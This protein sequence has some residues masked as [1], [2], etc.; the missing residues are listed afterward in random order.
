[1]TQTTQSIE[2]YR[3]FV[4]GEWVDSSSGAFFEVLNPY[5]GQAWARVPRGNGEDVNKAV[6]SAKKALESDSWKEMTGAARRNLL[7][8]LGKQIEQNAERLGMT[9]T[10]SN[11]K[12]Y[13]EIVPQAKS[14]SEFF[15]YYAGWAD[16]L[17]GE[18]I[19]LTETRDVLCYTLREP[20][21]VVA[22]VTPWNAPLLLTIMKMAPALA[23]GDTLVIKPSRYTPVTAIALA[24]MVEAAGFPPGVVNVVTGIGSEIGDTLL[25]HPD[26]NKISFTGSTDVGREV[27]R[28][29]SENIAKVTLELG[30]KSPNIVFEDAEMDNA[31]NGVLGGIFGFNGQICVAGSRVLL[32]SRIADEF[33]DR[34]V[35]RAR[36]IKLGDPMDIET[37][38]G[39]ISNYDQL[40]KVEQYVKL[41]QEE[42][43]VLVYG[44][45]KPD[46]SRLS[47]GMFYLPTIMRIRNNMKIG[48]E[49][50]FGPVV[51]IIEFDNDDEA[52]Q[53]AN[54][55][56]YGLA[57]GIWTSDI[58]RANRVVRRL[59]AG[60]VWINTYGLLPAAAGPFGGYKRSGVG[61]ENGFEAMEEYTQIKCVWVDLHKQIG[62]PF[63]Q[64][65]RS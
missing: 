44:G 10:K 23:A 1:M 63:R 17:V 49:E 56:R 12:L 62:D 50:I 59:K 13:R 30:G 60:T 37:E 39:P 20:I 52:V 38:M 22:A 55:I 58:R 29:A 5:T 45:K 65:S 2:T 36:T 15:Y 34:L 61:R 14:F 27:Y 6:A 57:A 32:H 54:D 64:P 33:L 51:G 7:L 26:V 3:M 41:G 9:E 11:G 4:D 28:S 24:E 8:A 35:R 40:T 47:N 42:G 25:R 31:V 43:G 16:K 18:T 48:Q 21:G 19:P 46:D 53:I